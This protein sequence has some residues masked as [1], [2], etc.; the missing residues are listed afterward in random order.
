MCLCVRY[1]ADY[2]DLDNPGKCENY[3]RLR[4]GW[5]SGRRGRCGAHRPNAHIEV[6]GRVV[7]VD[8]RGGRQ[9]Q[10]S[11]STGGETWVR[12]SVTNAASLPVEFFK[13]SFGAALGMQIRIYNFVMTGESCVFYFKLRSKKVNL[14]FVFV[15]SKAQL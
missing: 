13:E 10:T 5:H 8:G 3:P 15:F 4:N 14:P 9:A 12:A 7:C 11:V 1:L 2:S 6:L